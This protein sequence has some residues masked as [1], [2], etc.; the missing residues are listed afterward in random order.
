MWLMWPR[1]ELSERHAIS[2]IVRLLSS[3]LDKDVALAAAFCL[4][5]SRVAPASGTCACP[6]GPESI[7]EC[8]GGRVSASP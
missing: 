8:L 6:S 3:D 7:Y 5:L 1:L 2:S 4:L